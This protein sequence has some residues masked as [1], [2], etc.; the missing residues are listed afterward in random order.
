V[1]IGV[2]LV[3]G[4]E[5]L[6]RWIRES[7][8]ES[9]GSDWELRAG[10]PNATAFP[11][12]LCIW[13]FTVG[14]TNIPAAIQWQEHC[15]HCFLVDREDVAALQ[16]AAGTKDLNLIWKPVTRFFLDALLAGSL[17]GTAALRGERDELL[18]AL[19]QA[20]LRLQENEEERN[21]F[22]A[23]SVHDLRAPLTAITGYCG[24]LLEEELGPLTLEQQ[25]VLRRM[26]LSAARLSRISNGMF[27]LSIPR[28]VDTTL[29][30]ERVEI[31]DC[32]D[33]ALREVAVVLEDK[34][35]SIAA[36]IDRAPEGLLC[37]KAQLEET[38]VN[39]LDNACKFAPRDSVIEI[40]GYAYFWE[41]RG[42]QG[43]PLD[44]TSDRRVRPMRVLNSFRVDIRDSGPGIPTA[45]V[46]RIFE[47]CADGGG[48]QD[49]SGG[50]LGLAICRLFVNRHQGH[51]WVES[52]PLGGM[53][54][55]VLPLQRAVME[56]SSIEAPCPVGAR[57]D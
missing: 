33:Q 7:L 3:S 35:I 38:F 30:L 32:L 14:K 28:Y 22:L 5:V 51:I 9:F 2:R 24:L 15:K 17:P 27:Q 23:R 44:R 56:D 52:S 8:T 10:I 39:L 46:E 31:R 6:A 19:I 34:R 49:R 36:E 42:G 26:L 48:G 47:E 11:D 21:H 16:A 41:R 40:K 12:D 37:E 53:F 50:G 43:T 13:D 54:S 55:F 45:H 1:G 25:R 20:N 4:D 18:E 29:H 57:E